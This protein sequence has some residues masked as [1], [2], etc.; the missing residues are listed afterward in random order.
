MRKKVFAILYE[1]ASYT[2]DRNKMVY[3]KLGVGFCYMHR[4]SLAKAD[5]DND[6]DVLPTDK[7]PL[8]KRLMSILK[9]NDIIIMNGYTNIVFIILFLLN[10]WYKKPIGIDSDTQLVVPDN[11]IKRIAKS[12]YLNLIFR[13][14]HIFGLAGG[15]VTHKD[16]FRHYGMAENRIFL[17][18]MMVNN[19]KFA[20]TRD[21]KNEIFKFLYVGRIVSVKNIQILLDAFVRNFKDDPKVELH[22]VGIG[23]LLQ[24]YK[25][26][27]STY[28]N[29]VFEGSKYGKELADVYRKA[30]AF[31]LPSAFE[32]W[33]LVVNEAMSA[34][35]PCIVS[36]QVGAAWDLVD[37]KNT[38]FIFKYDNIE[39]LSD[40][41][42]TISSDSELYMKFSR[43]S[44][45]MM[46]NYWNY[47]L[48]TKCMEDYINKAK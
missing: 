25:T 8:I 28:K 30:D 34:G 29:I 12:L 40:K 38:G 21:N 2:E 43:N 7:V 9:D 41:M 1:P 10:I 32:P 35:L 5:S 24:S 46:H 47:E 13:N 27:Y 33:G 18:P 31:V 45:R 17:M 42:K 39:D 23:E 14:P 44:Y 11:K 16:L 3:D 26:T 19:E 15:T 6:I 20:F 22:I 4:H 48:Y 37:E 36:D